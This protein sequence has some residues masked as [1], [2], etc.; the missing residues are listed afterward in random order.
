MTH[1]LRQN[2]EIWKTEIS[3]AFMKGDRKKLSSLFTEEVSKNSWWTQ[4]QCIISLET[5]CAY[6]HL[7]LAKI[8]IKS[9]GDRNDIVNYRNLLLISQQNGHL[10]VLQWLMK[11]IAISHPRDYNEIQNSRFYKF[12]LACFEGNYM[13]VNQLLSNLTAIDAVTFIDAD[14]SCALRWAKKGKHRM[15]IGFLK[16][17]ITPK[18]GIKITRNKKNVV[19]K[20]LIETCIVCQEMPSQV[21]TSCN[22]SFCHTCIQ[23]W[24]KTSATKE[25]QLSG[26]CNCPYCRQSIDKLRPIT[27]KE[28]KNK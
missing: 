25:Q 2:K 15:L 5:C 3:L 6:G 13:V 16:Q 24:Y 9:F 7:E 19:F 26:T 14:N 23:K 28:K 21:E 10:D 4:Q 22:H 12:Q 11:S 18:S 17:K 27:L 1:Y 20:S 8:C